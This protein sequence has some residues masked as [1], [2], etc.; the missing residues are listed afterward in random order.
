MMGDMGMMGGM[1]P[2]LRRSTAEVLATVSNQGRAGRSWRL[3]A[4]LVATEPLRPPVSLPRS[5]ALGIRMGMGMGRGMTFAIN[6]R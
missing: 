6:G 5:F 2:I 3:P 1:G 4:R